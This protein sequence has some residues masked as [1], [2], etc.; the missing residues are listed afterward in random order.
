[1]SKIGKPRRA[2]GSAPEHAHK[3]VSESRCAQ[4]LEE[5]RFL[6][7]LAGAPQDDDTADLLAPVPAVRTGSVVG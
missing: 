4:E 1:M 2:A 5:Y 3:T 7:D 6:Y